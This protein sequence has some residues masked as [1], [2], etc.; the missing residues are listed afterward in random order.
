MKLS[1]IIPYRS[2]NGGHRDRIF[3]WIL[4]RYGKLYPDA[5]VCI[6]EDDDEPF[7][8]AAA[9]NAAFQAATGDTLLIADADTVFHRAFVEAGI[10]MLWRDPRSWVLPYD[11]KGYY[12]LT[13]EYTDRLLA[14]SA[15]RVYPPREEVEYVHELESWAGLLIVPREAF[16]LVGG[17]DDRFIGYGYE[18][19][20]F[21]MAMST[22]WGPLCRLDNA[23]TL[24]MW[25][26]QPNGD[27]FNH[28]HLGHNQ[29]LFGLYKSINGY[30]EG[31]KMLVE[32]RKSW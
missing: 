29:Q 5:E 20:A 3:N 17:Y 8:R 23:Y 24:H 26:P 28:P 31:M 32:A 9:R 21:S 22:L 18:D 16:E 6:G 13:E 10:Q 1:V 25:H 15:T 12:N 7:N 19:N 30:H 27:P 2:D 11:K 14:G 4:E